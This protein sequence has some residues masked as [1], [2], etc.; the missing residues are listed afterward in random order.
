M[1]NKQERYPLLKGEGLPNYKEIT[2][3]E[4]KESIPFLLGQLNQKVD[5]LEKILEEK[6]NKNISLRWA[7]VMVPLHLIEEKIRWSWG[8]VSHL[9]GVCNSPELREAY[10]EQQP[11]IIRFGNKVGQSRTIYKSLLSLKEKERDN[12]NETQLRILEAEITSM[13]HRGV[14]LNGS[15]KN[16]FNLNSERLAELSNIFSNHVLDATKAWSLVLTKEEEIL[17]LPSRVLEILANTAKEAGDKSQDDLEPTKEKGPWRVGLDMPSYIPFIT[18]S[19]NRHLRELIYK[20][21]VSRASEGL[22]DNRK[23]IEE[24]LTLRADQSKI[25][26]YNNWAEL[27]LTRK[28]AQNTTE[29]ENLLEELRSASLK[30]AKKELQELK[31]CALRHKSSEADKLE[32]WDI[33][34]WSE[35]LR[36]EKF[37]LNQEKLRPWFPLPKVLNGLF[38]LCGKLFEIQ[39]IPSKSDEAP[40]WHKDVKLFDV[41]DKDGSTL[42]SFYLD[43]YSRAATKRGG[44]WMDECLG[45]DIS[46]EGDKVLPV[47]YL[48]CNQTPPTEEAPSLMSFE[49]VETLFHE[50]GH[51]LQHMLTTVDYPQAAGINNVE[52]DAVEL[53]S[54][55]MENWCLDRSTLMGMAKHWKTDEPIPEEEFKKLKQSRTFNS[56][57]ATLRQVHF[58]ITDIR[59]HSQWNKDLGISP[60]QIRREI[61][62]STTVIDPIKEDQFLCSFSHIFAGGYAAGYYSYKWAEVL[63]SDAFSAFEEVGLDDVQ[64]VSETG[65][66]FRDTVLSLGGSRSP[67]KVFEAFRGRQPSTKALIR[68]SGL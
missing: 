25:L 57:M 35:K 60:D 41:L 56:G 38:K 43:P 34:Y 16:S 7:D 11:E 46:L 6:I 68:H 50:F 29:V 26:G 53:P 55:F 1:I 5:E 61:A 4:I 2:P 27:S 10:A 51:G 63:S 30:V 36:V 58:A 65:R 47:A 62:K 42:A 33:S 15:Q 18:Y 54:Q 22:L 37:S 31:D 32:P 66:R 67:S 21:H 59:L 9:N 24:I 28:M 45:K 14:G 64:K 20:A 8:V 44:A 52:W 13:N 48:I 3:E 23:I 12:L 19:D 49:E 40:T 39:I 17:G